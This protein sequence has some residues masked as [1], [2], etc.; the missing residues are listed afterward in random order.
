MHQAKWKRY[1]RPAAAALT[2]SALTEAAL[3]RLGQTYGSVPAEQ[4]MPLLGDDIVPD[5]QVVTNHAIDIDAPPG[6]V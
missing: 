6:C 5:P 1:V 2:T 3:I 4:A